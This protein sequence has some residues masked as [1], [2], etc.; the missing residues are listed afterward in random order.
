MILPIRQAEAIWID[1]DCH[2]H[3]WEPDFPVAVKIA[4]GKVDAVT[5][6]PWRPG[7]G[8][9]QDY[10]VCPE[11]PWLDGFAVAPGII[12]QFVAMPLGTG[13]P[14]EEQVTG[15]ARW[16]GL[17]ISVTPLGRAAWERMKEE[18]GGRVGAF[19]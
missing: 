6:E 16:G 14:A 10:L 11:Q 19:L 12:R 2:G 15:A 18:A 3:G 1:S 5:G 4:A 8:V 7:L 13:Y 9:P 17:Q